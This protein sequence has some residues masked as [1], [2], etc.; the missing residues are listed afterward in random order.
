MSFAPLLPALT[1]DLKIVVT[2]RLK[3]RTIDNFDFFVEKLEA[4]FGRENI[5]T[6]NEKPLSRKL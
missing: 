3:L 5:T 6:Y 1:N 2:N 4:F